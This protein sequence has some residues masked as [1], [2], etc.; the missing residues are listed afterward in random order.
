MTRRVVMVCGAP[1]GA[2]NAVADYAWLLARELA[3]RADVVFISPREV[4][5]EPGSVRH[6][7]VPAGW[8]IRAGRE[9]VRAVNAARPDV[10]V[11]HF[12]PQMYGWQ[13]LKPWFSLMLLALA[14]KGWPIVTVAHEFRAP[15]SLH[16]LR[17]TQAIG[18]R[19]LFHLVARASRD[20]VTTTTFCRDL[21]TRGGRA[22]GRRVH[23]IPVTATLPIVELDAAERRAVRGRLAI[24]DDALFVAVFGTAVE[25]AVAAIALVT[26]RIARENPTARF[27]VLGQESEQ[28]T[29]R[30]GTEPALSGRVTATG[31]LPGDELS[32]IV[33]ASDL[34]A[35]CYADG[36][37]TRRTSLMIGLAHGVA[38]LSNPG[39]LTDNVL[40]SGAVGLI[41][42]PETLDRPLVRRLCTDPHERAALGAR[43]RRLYESRFA[44]PIIA[45][46][47]E[48]L[49]A[50]L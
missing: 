35:V 25:E 46:E 19:L 39:I 42:D 15:W 43:G 7:R 16:P 24:A 2:G 45:A 30:L 29:E 20:I 12:V 6:H 41:A 49:F 11:V 26:R 3:A 44:P 36:A 34:Y 33:A 47:Y 21:L 13:G 18:H 27:V 23:A 28:L 38:T 9:T 37:S 31:A 48:R 32:A 4:P 1:P 40:R 17:L 10:V 22:R 8:G 14:A 50:A 5:A